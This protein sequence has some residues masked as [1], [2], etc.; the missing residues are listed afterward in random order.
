[1][2][3]GTAASSASTLGMLL[4][5][6]LLTVHRVEKQTGILA[7]IRSIW[8]GSYLG[9]SL[10]PSIESR[11]ITTKALAYLDSKVPGR[12]LES[13]AASSRGTSRYWDRR[14][15]RSRVSTS[16]QPEISL[17]TPTRGKCGSGTGRQQAPQWLERHHRELRQD[18]TLAVRSAGGLAR[19]T[20]LSPPLPRFETSRSYNTGRVGRKSSVIEVNSRFTSWRQSG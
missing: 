4:I 13:P 14:A 3:P 18:W 12:S 19:W 5:S 17:P 9:L 2:T 6:I 20:T 1:M 7:R 15:I 10:V 16:R 11:L 8:V